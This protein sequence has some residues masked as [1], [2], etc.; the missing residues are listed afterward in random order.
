MHGHSK[1]GSHLSYYASSLNQ[2]EKSL[3]NG[4][5][6]HVNEILA[7]LEGDNAQNAEKTAEILA[8]NMEYEMQKKECKAAP[9]KKDKTS[10]APKKMRGEASQVTQV[11]TKVRRVDQMK[12][13][14]SLKHIQNANINPDKKTG[15]NW[16]HED[17][18]ALVKYVIK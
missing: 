12:T 3:D 15:H 17:K 7:D 6:D 10:S 4:L 1:F 14:A 5:G 9:K 11:S 8:G 16:P 18:L 2:S 13:L